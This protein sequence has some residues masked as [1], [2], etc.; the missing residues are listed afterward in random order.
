MTYG[1]SNRYSEL[2]MSIGAQPARP[3]GVFTP[4]TRAKVVPTLSQAT[5]VSPAMLA[6]I[7]APLRVFACWRAA[8]RA[9]VLTLHI[10]LPAPPDRD[11]PLPPKRMQQSAARP[12]YPAYRVDALCSTSESHPRTSAING[13]IRRNV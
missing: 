3:F 9:S 10:D 1:A 4:S 12:Q 11:G 8:A 5:T 6:V 2:P 13:V 7:L